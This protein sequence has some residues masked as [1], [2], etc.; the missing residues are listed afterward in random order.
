VLDWIVNLPK[1]TNQK[2]Y[3]YVSYSQTKK[4]TNSKDELIRAHA[5]MSIIQEIYKTPKSQNELSSEVI[6]IGLNKLCCL[7][8]SYTIKQINKKSTSLSKIR[9]IFVTRGEHTNYKLSSKWGQLSFFE[10]LELETVETAL[11]KLKVNPSTIENRMSQKE[12]IKLLFSSDEESSRNSST[13][14]S[15]IIAESESNDQ[16]SAQD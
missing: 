3:D 13:S 11:I 12:D 9:E 6:Y 7:R 5:E 1:N 15:I 16:N 10:D 4:G 14:E 2:F 8:C